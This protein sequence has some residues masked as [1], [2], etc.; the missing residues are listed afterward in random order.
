MTLFVGRGTEFVTRYPGE[1]CAGVLALFYCTMLF[2]VYRIFTFGAIYE[3]FFG[4]PGGAEPPTVDDDDTSR[5]WW[6]PREWQQR[7]SECEGPST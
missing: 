2:M 1:V 5:T 6:M 4:G 3:G 7:D